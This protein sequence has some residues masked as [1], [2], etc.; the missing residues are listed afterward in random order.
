VIDTRTIETTN[1]LQPRQTMNDTP[2]CDTGLVK[3]HFFEGEEGKIPERIGND[4]TG[5]K[6]FLNGILPADGPVMDRTER[7]KRRRA[8]NFSVE[9]AA[10]VSAELR[11]NID[12]MDID[13]KRQLVYFLPS[14][15]KL[16]VPTGF[17]LR[18]PWAWHATVS[19]N[20]PQQNLL[21]SKIDGFTSITIDSTYRAEV[22]I[23]LENNSSSTIPIYHHQP[24]MTLEFD[25][26]NGNNFPIFE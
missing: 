20:L 18:L 13:G 14:N 10:T 22:A 16:W 8:W 2:I 15:G 17:I 4:S 9:T 25:G 21:P 23:L 5:Y 7:Y 24:V 6:I 3:I 19:A 1:K 26:P 12:V 11:K